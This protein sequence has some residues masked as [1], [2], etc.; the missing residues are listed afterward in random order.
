MTGIGAGPRSK[1]AFEAAEAL[2]SI[3]SD[4]RRSGRRAALTQLRPAVPQAS[5]RITLLE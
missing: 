2:G 1:S 3:F 4:R 5:P